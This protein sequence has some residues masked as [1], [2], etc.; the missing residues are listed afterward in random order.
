MW[1][2]KVELLC[3]Y[4]MSSMLVRVR[5]FKTL[6]NV[7]LPDFVVAIIVFIE[8]KQ[9]NQ[10]SYIRPYVKKPYNKLRADKKIKGSIV[11]IL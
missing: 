7:F 10:T 9:W 2:V 6:L 8:S 4:N 1:L 5:V 11:R 3:W